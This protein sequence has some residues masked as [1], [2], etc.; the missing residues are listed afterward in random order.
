MNRDW[1]SEHCPMWEGMAL[2]VEIRRQLESIESPYQKIDVYQTATYGNMLVLDGKI[3]CTERDEF[4]YHEMLVH[5]ALYAHPNPQRVLIIGGGDGGALREVLKHESVTKCTLC[6]IDE[7]VSD[8][9]R[10]YFPQMAGAL[11]LPRADLH[12]ADGI[13][14]LRESIEKFDVI[15]ID[16]T[17]PIGPAEVL[18]GADFYQLVAQHLSENGI[19]AAQ[20]GSFFIHDPTVKAL[21]DAMTTHFAHYA[22]LFAHVPSYPGGGVGIAVATN[23]KNVQLTQP[24][25]DIFITHRYYNQAIHTAA[26]VL[27]TFA[28]QE[29]TL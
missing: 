6:D 25:R 5:P 7:A 16:S 4:A 13:I 23:S 29:G 21:R 24:A 26:S 10:K 9:S 14:Y 17:D 2:S 27:P 22:Y 3:Q 12:Y 18:F 8:M 20:S 11:D 19:V 15:I 1:F 28:Q